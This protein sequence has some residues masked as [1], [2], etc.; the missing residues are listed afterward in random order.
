MDVT[1][2]FTKIPQDEGI[3]TLCKALDC[4]YE[5]EIPISTPAL[6]GAVILQENSFQFNGKKIFR[7]ETELL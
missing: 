4:F 1:T 6:E 7:D 3:E 2:F 5:T